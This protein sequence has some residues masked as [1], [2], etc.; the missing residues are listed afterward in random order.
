MPPQMEPQWRLHKAGRRLSKKVRDKKM[1]L[2][3]KVRHKKVRNKKVRNKMNP[4]WRRHKTVVGLNEMGPQWRLRKT[5]VRF[6]LKM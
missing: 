6:K 5:V 2:N 1:L 3:K 4:Q